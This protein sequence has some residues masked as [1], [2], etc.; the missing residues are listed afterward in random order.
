MAPDGIAAIPEVPIWLSLAVIL[1][2][3]AVATVAS[4][5]RTSAAARD[6]AEDVTAGPGTPIE[7]VSALG[8]D[9]RGTAAPP[10]R[11]DG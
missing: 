11:L 2:T 6:R 10:G 9:S 5:A 8:A 1:G 3:L 7:P 4:L